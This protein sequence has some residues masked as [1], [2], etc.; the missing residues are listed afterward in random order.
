VSFLS[1]PTEIL[2]APP[3]P[4]LP[5]RPWESFTPNS[6]AQAWVFNSWTPIVGYSGRLGSSKTRTI[7]ECALWDALFWARN[8]VLVARK[9]A[10]DLFA[11][12]WPIFMEEVL[13]PELRRLY[14]P[15]AQGGATLFLPNGS[16]IFAFGLDEPMKVR[17]AQYGSIYVD[18]AEDLDD[19]GPES[20]RKTAESRLRHRVPPTVLTAEDLER[21]G[22]MAGRATTRLTAANR[23]AD[24]VTENPD[25][26]VVPLRRRIVYAFNPD[27]DFHWGNVQFRFA[28]MQRLPPEDP[29]HWR[30]VYRTLEPMKLLGGT[31]VPAGR[32]HAEAIIARPTDNTENLPIDYQARLATYV[33]S[34]KDRYVGGRWGTFEGQVL[35]NFR[36]DRH[37]IRRPEE[38][39][40]WGGYPPPHWRRFRVVDFGYAPGHPFVMSWYA[41]RPRTKEAREC[42]FL[43][44]E[45]YMTGRLV[46]DH[47]K[48][49]TEWDVDELAALNRGIERWNAEHGDHALRTR[50]WLE[51][52][53]QVCD[54]DAEDR[55]TLEACG[56]VMDRAVKD[57]QPGAQIVAEYLGE[58]GQEPRILFVENARRERDQTLRE[59][60]PSCTWEELSGI[61]WLK[62]KVASADKPPKDDWAKVNDHGFDA[63][64]YILLSERERGSQDA[65]MV[66]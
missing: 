13:P 30:Q 7:C 45:I 62:Q 60:A 4:E 19:E 53:M 57:R 59:G 56:I 52:S 11:T 42:W 23:H 28:D 2:E 6:E 54:W 44:Q 34:W 38:W 58:D 32:P 46:G 47:A 48:Q 14:R 1:I 12:T 5:E 43:Y 35:P 18:Q 51:Y 41:R 24:R 36:R 65:V 3:E 17:G 31:T 63:L 37:V 15:G 50:K 20:E 61:R 25:E 33:G 22:P 10:T 8:R 40:R 66:G 21:L 49:A 16:R 64:R 55:A 26:L 9:R 39:D 27:G 29:R